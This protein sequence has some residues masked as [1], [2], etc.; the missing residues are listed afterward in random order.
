[1]KRI[2]KLAIP[3]GVDYRVYASTCILHPLDPLYRFYKIALLPAI[4]HNEVGDE[5]WR[6]ADDERTNYD[7]ESTRQS[8]L[9]QDG[10]SPLGTIPDNPVNVAIGKKYD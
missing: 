6:P 3:Y 5:E 10:P 8:N 2:P 9:H 1:M 7:G 4:I